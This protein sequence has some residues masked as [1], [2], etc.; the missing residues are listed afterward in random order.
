MFGC[1]DDIL[2][3]LKIRYYFVMFENLYFEIESV[4]GCVVVFGVVCFVKLICFKQYYYFELK[5]KILFVVGIICGGFKSCYYIDFLVQSVGVKG[6]YC[7]VEYCIKLFDS[8]FSDYF[9][10]VMDDVG[11]DYCIWM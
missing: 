11:W 6:G 7:D 8:L 4:N 10:G 9:F 2:M 1:G 5:Q 3:I